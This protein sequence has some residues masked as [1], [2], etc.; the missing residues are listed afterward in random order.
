M[1]HDPC[2]NVG[3][4]AAKADWLDGVGTVVFSGSINKLALSLGN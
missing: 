1:L 3:S 2:A 4:T